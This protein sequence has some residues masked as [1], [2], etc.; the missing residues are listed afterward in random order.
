MG[1]PLAEQKVIIKDINDH[2]GILG[3]QV[4][5]VAHAIDATSTAPY[6]QQA[7]EECADFHQDHH[8][9]A[10]LDE[11]GGDVLRACTHKAGAV[12]VAATAQMFTTASTFQRY[13]YFVAPAGISQ[14][15][16]AAAWTPALVDQN[17]FTPWNIATGKPGGPLPVRVGVLTLDTPEMQYAVNNILAP[18]LKAAGHPIYDTAFV[19]PPNS[20]ADNGATLSQIQSAVLRFRND[21]ITHFLP[22]DS[23]A[24][25]S[26][27]FGKNASSQH[28]Y[29]RFGLNSG[30][31]VQVLIDAGLMP[32]DE[33]NGAVGYGWESL[34]DVDNGH[35]PPDG[36][37][38]NAARQHCVELMKKNGFDMSGPAQRGAV[39]YCDQFYFLKAAMEAGGEPASRDSF[40]AGVNRLGTSF[41]AGE[42]FV[43]SL[44]ASQHDGVAAS[45]YFDFDNGCGCFLYTS[46]VRRLS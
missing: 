14:D 38:S 20:T 31:G 26:L 45:R 27:Y 41:V 15:R 4:K 12:Q 16:I 1:D 39:E 8:V 29:P 13:P 10:V 44:A 40:L 35:N 11:F 3:R 30:D 23:A 32:T 7:Q 46:G 9:F 2:G 6:D 28:Y 36:K 21:N 5:F 34:L 18:A 17:Y 25:L 19:K 37:Y 24:G 42:T 22:F 43:S 33:L